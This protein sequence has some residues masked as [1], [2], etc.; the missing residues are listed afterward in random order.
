MEE[1]IGS[2]L[3]RVALKFDVMTSKV[4]SKVVSDE[5]MNELSE[6]VRE[7]R[8]RLDGTRPKNKVSY[9]ALSSNAPPQAL[10]GPP[11]LPPARA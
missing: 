1:K 2:E 7:E 3:A 9:D 6:R 11:R 4:D 10:L 5:R 8:D